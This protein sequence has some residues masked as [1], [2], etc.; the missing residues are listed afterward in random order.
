VPDGVLA[1]RIDPVTGIRADNDENGIYEYFY[2]ENPPPEIEIPLP[3]M[4][5][6]GTFEA[7]DP[8][9]SQPQRM[10]QPEIVMMPKP[11]NTKPIEQSP[12]EQQNSTNNPASR[13]LGSH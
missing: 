11:T 6:S 7:D 10:L 12:K 8:L 3:S 1:L 4:L 2:H 13:L 9:M 5:D